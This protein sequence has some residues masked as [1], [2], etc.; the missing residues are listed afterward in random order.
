MTPFARSRLGVKLSVQLMTGVLLVMGLIMAVVS[1]RVWQAAKDNAHHYVQQSAQQALGLVATFEESART[2]AQR[3]FA[4]FK[5]R[6]SG[7]FDLS[8]DDQG[9]PQLSHNF[10]K[11]NGQFEDVDGFTKQTG[12]SVATVFARTGD[13]FLRIATSLTKQD[14]SR[15]MGTTLDHKHPAYERMLKGE[16]YVGRAQ[17]FGRSYMT[18]YEPIKADGQVI[19][20]LFIGTDIGPLLAK[21]DTLLAQNVLYESGKVFTLSQAQIDNEAWAG[22]FAKLPAEGGDVLGTLANPNNGQAQMGPSNRL[23]I[24]LRGS[25]PS[26]CTKP[27][28]MPSITS[29][30]REWL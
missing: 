11:I 28:L 30:S 4:L 17:L 23:R 21:L 24:R 15:A 26:P 13:D 7:A 5:T 3:D 8:T 29:I 16:S 12:G 10:S 2:Q 18:V 9:V 6:W 20:I 22:Q 25:N 1:Q 14:G 27:P 19:G